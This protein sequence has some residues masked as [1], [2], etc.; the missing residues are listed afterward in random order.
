MNEQNITFA[1]DHTLLNST[2]EVTRMC[3][4]LFQSLPIKAFDLTRIYSFGASLE[5]STHNA[6]G[7]YCYENSKFFFS[8]I[9]DEILKS[10]SYYYISSQHNLCPVSELCKTMF[11]VDNLFLIFDKSENF[12]DLYCYRTAVDVNSNVALN[13]Y[14]NHLDLL[15]DHG[16]DFRHSAK[17]LIEQYHQKGH[18]IIPPNSQLEKH[19][20]VHHSKPLSLIA[21]LKQQFSLREIHCI[22]YLL[23]GYS[24]KETGQQLCLSARTVEKYLDNIRI[25][26]D[27]ISKRDVIKLLYRTYGER[28]FE[29]I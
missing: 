18:L 12:V 3:Q 17:H 7:K 25:K 13:Q 27:C 26:L 15:I 20:L 29:L 14:L 21:E 11:D 22:K 9:P 1:K 2:D 4:P 28:F 16:R 10:T 6:L 8:G 5:L 24:S 19:K 23:L